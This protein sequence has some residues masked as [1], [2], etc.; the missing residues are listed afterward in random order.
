MLL[1]KIPPARRIDIGKRA[2]VTAGLLGVLCILAE[3][4]FM[5]PH[6]LVSNDARP[7]YL[8]H[9]VLLRSV[10]HFAIIITFVLGAVSVLLIKSKTYGLASIGLAMIAVLMGG[11]S[12]EP[13]THE[14][15]AFSA[16]LDYFV[17]ELLILGLLFIPMERLWSLHPDQKIFRTGWQT[18]LK[19]FFVSH[20]G[21]QLIAFATLIPVQVP[22]AH[23]LNMLFGDGELPRLFLRWHSSE[24][25]LTRRQRIRLLTRLNRLTKENPVEVISEKGSPAHTELVSILRLLAA[26]P[27]LKPS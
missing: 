10:L 27:Q 1:D 24:A 19:H 25:K 6:I 9:I 4:C 13:V 23:E 3:L 26:R 5:F 16:G 11:S 2:G 7:H 14:P 22:T 20:A 18:D 21:V 12:V 17:L 8:E 15:R